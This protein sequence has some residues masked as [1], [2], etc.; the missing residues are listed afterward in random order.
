MTIFTNPAEQLILALDGMDE[1]DVFSFIDKL[2]E[3]IWVKIGL[4]LFTLAGPEIVFKLRDKGKRIFLDLKFHDIPTTM[5]K[6]SYRAASTGAELISVHACAGKK[7]LEYAKQGADEGAKTANLTKPNL[8]AVTILT[9]WSNNDFKNELGIDQ[10]LNKRVET[11]AS[12]ACEAGITGLVC[13]PLEVKKLRDVYPKPFELVTP[14]I[15]TSND[16]L[17][18]QSR[19]MNPVETIKN[20]SSKIVLGRLITQNPNPTKLFRSI[21]DELALS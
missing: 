20:G 4:E 21:C 19:V 2:P 9:S 12:L 11:L 5:A 6:A 18:D 7:A 16:Q 1:S 3:L 10:S 17:K 8:L 15:R 14:G 13:S